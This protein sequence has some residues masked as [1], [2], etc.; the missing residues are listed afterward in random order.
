MF[1]PSGGE[2]F[3]VR[4]LI[5]LQAAQ[6]LGTNPAPIIIGNRLPKPVDQ[7]IQPFWAIPLLAMAGLSVQD[8]PDTP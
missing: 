2:Q 1:V 6:E 4:G 5:S 8:I 3:P 7:K